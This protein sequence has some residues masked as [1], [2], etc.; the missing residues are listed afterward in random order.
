MK[1]A[2]G[3]AS[4]QRANCF[5]GNTSLAKATVRR[6][7]GF[8]FRKVPKEEIMVRAET[9]QQTVLIRYSF[10]NSTSFTGNMNSCRGI[11]HTV[12]P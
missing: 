9:T 12:P 11:S 2:S 4:R 8:T 7:L 10:R 5:M 6:Y 1:R 3:S